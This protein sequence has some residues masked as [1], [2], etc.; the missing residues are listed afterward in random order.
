MG[1]IERLFG[2]EIDIKEEKGENRLIKVRFP[3]MVGDENRMITV[4]QLKHDYKDYLIFDPRAGEQVDLE[5]LANLSDI[6]EVVC[7]PPI[8]GGVF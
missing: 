2:K 6:D 3:S 4:Q 1:I 8:A 5:K 7:M